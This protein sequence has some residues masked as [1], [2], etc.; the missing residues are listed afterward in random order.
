MVSGIAVGTEVVVERAVA[1]GVGRNCMNCWASGV[2][3][4]AGM[5]L[6][7]KG[8]LDAPCRREGRCRG[9][10]VDRDQV[11]LGVAPVAEVARP[12][13]E[14]GDGEG[15]PVGAT[16]LPEALD[17]HVEVALDG[18]RPEAGDLG[19]AADVGPEVVL[20]ERGLLVAAPLAWRSGRR[21]GGS[22]RPRRGTCRV[23]DLVMA[24]IWPEVLAPYCGS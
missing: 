18:V 7:G 20:L 24:M 5:M 8:L 11:A 4:F 23:P 12:L 3:R 13:L 9:R 6:P 17:V 15:R 14:R 19:R 22:R 10:V 16:R 1:R 21:S 2:I